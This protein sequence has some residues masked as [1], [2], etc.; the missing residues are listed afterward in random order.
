M[1]H[2]RTTN[3]I[4]SFTAAPKSARLCAEPV[5]AGSGIRI[6][7]AIELTSRRLADWIA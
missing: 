3:P 1:I 2:N 5:Y 7:I 4:E 6:C